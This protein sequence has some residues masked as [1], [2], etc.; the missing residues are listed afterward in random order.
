LEPR[1]KGLELSMSLIQDSVRLKCYS[2]YI[3][4]QLAGLL[5]RVEIELTSN[6]NYYTSSTTL[7][8]RVRRKFHVAQIIIE[9]WSYIVW[10]WILLT[11]KLFSVYYFS[12]TQNSLILI[13]SF[14]FSSYFWLRQV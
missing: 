7:K 10:Q 11:C 6:S 14:L 1:L 3:H 12:P 8:T 13:W 2:S 9:G 4:D 5:D